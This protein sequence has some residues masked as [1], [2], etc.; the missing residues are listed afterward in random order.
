MTCS[1]CRRAMVALELHGIEAD[2]CPACGSVW[3]D[4]GELE[5]L[6]GPEAVS[7]HHGWFSDAG[8]SREKRVRCP[9]C[10]CRMQKKN[11]DS[12]PPVALDVCSRGHGLWFDK[13]ELTEVL[14]AAAPEQRGEVIGLLKDMFRNQTDKQRS[15]T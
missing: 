6:L 5:E 3:L 1:G 15:G 9:V 12:R 2:Y 11:F 7:R 14:G 13:G 4:K 8:A 10:R